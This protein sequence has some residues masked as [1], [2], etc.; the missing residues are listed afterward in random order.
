MTDNARNPILEDEVHYCEKHPDRDTE[1]RCNRCDRYMCIQC[2]VRTP[3]GYTCVD[4]VR[5]QEDKFYT[6]TQADYAIV[7]IISVIG[8]AIGAFI[9]GLVGIFFALIIS[10]AVGGLVGQLALTVTGRRRGRYSGY[11]CAGAVLVGGLLTALFLTG[12]GLT[13]LLYL[14]LAVSTA[15]TSYKVSI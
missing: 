12:L 15:Y 6:G 3:V 11:I 8:G 9:V 1:L 14:G 5:G 7:A 2:A 13:S 10:P 4:C